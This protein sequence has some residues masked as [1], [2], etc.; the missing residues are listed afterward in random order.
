MDRSI[1]QRPFF[2]PCDQLESEVLQSRL[3]QEAGPEDY[4]YIWRPAIE[5][6][7]QNLGRDLRNSLVSEI[8]DAAEEV[9]R[10]DPGQLPALLAMLEGR[11]WL[12][13]HRLAL[14]L[15]RL[16]PHVEPSLVTERL[17]DRARF[18][19]PG[20]RHEYALLAR[21]HFGQLSADEQ[22]LILGWIKA[23]PEGRLSPGKLVSDEQTERQVRAWR[24]VRLAPIRDSLPPAWRRC[25]REWAA[26]LGEPEHPD[27]LSYRTGVP[28]RP[29]HSPCTEDPRSQDVKKSSRLLRCLRAPSEHQLMAARGGRR[30]TMPE[31]T[32]YSA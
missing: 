17:T 7:A 27:F 9:I 26:E 29:T 6:H 10:A 24:L 5:E 8:R 13:F 31:A 18:D 23:G 14:H 32:N 22:A 12:I 20:L 28:M 3:G 1:H 21:D 2:L 11:S 19:A 30:S 15:L 4:S 25:Y 16:F